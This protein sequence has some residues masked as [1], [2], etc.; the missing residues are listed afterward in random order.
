MRRCP[1]RSIGCRATSTFALLAIVLASPWLARS[2]Q[3]QA[4]DAADAPPVTAVLLSDVAAI[5]PGSSF[6][7]GV[8]F[9]I[10]K[11]WNIYW[12]NPGSSGLETSLELDVPS[13]LKAGEVRWPGPKRKE[14]PGGLL[15]YV[16]DKE[17]LLIVPIEVES[18]LTPGASIEIRVR[19][20]WLACKGSCILGDQELSLTL[21][22]AE[23][24][25]PSDAAALIRQHERALPH[26]LEEFERACAVSWDNDTLVITLPGANKLAFFP[27]ESDDWELLD[28]IRH[29]A[30]KAETL[31][32]PIRFK[33]EDPSLEVTG[34]LA[35]I[36]DKKHTL[37]ITI[38]SARQAEAD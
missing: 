11:G 23:K 24:A 3:A 15:D 38:A 17:A 20:D 5:A 27:H 30:A 8:H 28:P 34:V 21:P 9:K 10:E 12:R 22:V 31:R 19:A 18:S 4:I 2:A 25:R 16:Y 29:G 32:L 6:H 14:S 36:D 33:L 35:L 13:G 37:Y 26:P 1:K 7:L